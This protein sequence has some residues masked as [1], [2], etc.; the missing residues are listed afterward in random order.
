MFKLFI[1]S[2]MQYWW[3]KMNIKLTMTIFV[4]CSVTLPYVWCLDLTCDTFVT[5]FLSYVVV[6]NCYYH[7]WWIKVSNTKKCEPGTTA[8]ST[9]TEERVPRTR[10][11]IRRSLKLIMTLDAPPV[12]WGSKDRMD[13]ARPATTYNHSRYAASKYTKAQCK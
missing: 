13:S 7:I 11:I 4:L 3:I 5:S 1:M 8:T 10:K 9:E 6:F 2:T 12:K